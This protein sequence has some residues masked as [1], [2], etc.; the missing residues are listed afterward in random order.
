MNESNVGTPSLDGFKKPEAI[1]ELP[2]GI[3]ESSGL[4]IAANDGLYS[5]NDSGG[6]ARI[7][8]FSKEGELIRKIK[9]TDEKN[10]D[11][12]ELASDENYLYIGDTG[13]NAGKRKNLMIYQVSKK[14]LA[15]SNEVKGKKIRFSYP[16]QTSFDVKKHNFDCE[17]F[18]AMNGSIYLFTKNRGNQQSS[19]YRIPAVPG[20]YKAKLI[21]TFDTDG[22]ITGADISPDQKTVAL[23]GYNYIGI[24]GYDP[25]LWVLSD[26][27]GDDFFS[28]K[29]K[30]YDFNFNR[31][32]EAICFEDNQTIL[33]TEEE[34]NVK[35]SYLYRMKI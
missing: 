28:G 9:V 31:Q 4:A 20:E 29:Q 15:K 33:F 26:F 11:W 5:H 17:G 21:S 34:E 30:R 1:A 2:D 27:S 22:L 24:Q 7:F 25:F 19:L 35:K 3:E 32:T 14:S 10:Y 13:N 12:E 16:E 8:E 23:I 6:K 18:F